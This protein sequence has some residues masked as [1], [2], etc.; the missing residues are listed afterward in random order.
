M[1][2]R[3]KHKRTDAIHCN[4]WLWLKSNDIGA[5]GC[6]MN[7]WVLY[8]DLG[9]L[10]TITDRRW[11]WF[12]T[13]EQLLQRQQR[14]EFLH[15]IETRDNDCIFYDNLYTTNLL[16]KPTIPLQTIGIGYD[17]FFSDVHCEENG[18]NTRKDMSKLFFW[19][20]TLGPISQR[21]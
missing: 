15:R 5:F 18:R 4:K 3:V 1:K 9:A 6:Y 14:K 19:L 11:R 12:F 17:R 2:I 16:Q 10:W 13:C 21:S 8:G 20:K 7:F